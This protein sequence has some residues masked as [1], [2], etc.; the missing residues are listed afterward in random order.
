[1]IA[2]RVQLQRRVHFGN[3]GAA[4]AKAA[5]RSGMVWGVAGAIGVLYFAEKIPFIRQDIMS[6]LPVVGHLY[7]VPEESE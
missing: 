2:P 4:T 1:M 7:V 6:K 5:M 3:F